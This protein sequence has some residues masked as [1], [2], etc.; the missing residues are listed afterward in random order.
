[1]SSVKFYVINKRE[2]DNLVS[3]LGKL[4]SKPINISDKIIELQNLMGE[5]MLIETRS[6]TVKE[7]NWR[8]IEQVL[9]SFCKENNIS[10]EDIKSSSRDSEIVKYRKEFFYQARQMGFNNRLI[11]KTINRNHS[12]VS[13]YLTKKPSHV[14]PDKR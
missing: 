7:V 2:L 11:A 10:K 14:S 12:T 13:Y 5:A 3:Q 4:T 9:D 1:M 6:K 8:D